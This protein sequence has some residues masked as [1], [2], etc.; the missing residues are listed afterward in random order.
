MEAMTDLAEWLL[1]QYDADEHFARSAVQWL[2]TRWDP[3]RRATQ[4]FGLEVYLNDSDGGRRIAELV[5]HA[6]AP[7]DGRL[8]VAVHIARHDPAAVLADL[9]AKRRIVARHIPAQVGPRAG[10]DCFMDGD[11]YPC[12]DLRL[13]ALPYA[14]REGYD[15]AWAPDPDG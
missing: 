11:L 12:E 7:G 4:D 9:A 1:A 8:D 10:I 6:D 15:P 2:G 13:L 5:E 3:G 14:A